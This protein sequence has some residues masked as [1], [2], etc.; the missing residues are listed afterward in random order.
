MTTPP[1]PDQEVAAAIG[2]IIAGSPDPYGD[3]SVLRAKDPR[4]RL[5]DG[6]C[7]MTRREDVV[8]VLRD[9]RFG[10]LYHERQ[11]AL[12]GAGELERSRLLQSRLRWFL[13]MDP[14][15]HGRLRGLVQQ[16]FTKRAFFERAGRIQVLVDEHLDRALGLGDFDVVA[17]FARPLTVDTIGDLL[18][19]PQKDRTRFTDWG[20]MFEALPG[21]EAFD[22]AER[23][24]VEYEDYFSEL[25]QRKRAV[26]GE[27]LLSQLIAAECEGD[28]LDEDELLA[29]AFSLFGAGF[30][31]TRNLI[32][33]ATKALLEHPEQV[34]LLREDPSRVRYAV[35]EAL[36]FDA[37]VQFTTRAALE[38]VEVG[39]E[40]FRRGEAFYLCLGAA[41]RDPAAYADPDVFDIL[42]ERPQPATFGGGIHHCVGAAMG[43]LETQ[44]ALASLFERAP[45]LRVS[46]EPQWSSGAVFRGLRT[47]PVAS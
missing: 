16:V 4:L 35:E 8:S 31:T 42:R 3:Y 47:L 37:P 6:T 20:I 10:H 26:P 5:P 12:W 36:R 1:S 41:N 32:G 19:V 30:D 33:N 40:T 13:F 44:L 27:D 25:L 46:D 29:T 28:R 2:R 11:R 24:I 17:D 39:G 14:P 22:H 21:A 7:V 9:P 38:D 18:G 15:D 43:R 34:A 23:L 45:R